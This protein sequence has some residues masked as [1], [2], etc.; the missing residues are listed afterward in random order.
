VATGFLADPLHVLVPRPPQ[1]LLREPVDFDVVLIP[2]PLGEGTIERV[3]FRCLREWS[4]DGDGTPF[5]AV[6]ELPAAARARPQVRT[7]DVARF[8]EEMDATGDDVWAAMESTGGLPVG[9]REG[10]SRDVLTRLL[11]VERRQRAP[12]HR[13][14]ELGAGDRYGN[15]LCKFLCLNCR[16]A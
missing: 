15:W 11:D 14:A 8:D 16:P 9:T 12:Q 1:D 4:R 7:L 3:A 13:H 5:L 10:P 6:L 2:L